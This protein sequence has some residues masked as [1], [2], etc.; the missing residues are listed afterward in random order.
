MKNMTAALLF[1]KH[2]L[3]RKA[4]VAATVALTSLGLTASAGA[5]EPVHLVIKS[6]NLDFSSMRNTN[7][8]T[9]CSIAIDSNLVVANEG[10][11]D[12]RGGYNDALIAQSCSSTVPLSCGGIIWGASVPIYQLAKGASVTY[13]P[14]TTAQKAPFTVNCSPPSPNYTVLGGSIVAKWASCRA[15]ITC[16]P[17]LA[18]ATED[19]LT[20]CPA[21][22]QKN[23]LSACH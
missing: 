2:S 1:E 19:L 22:K 11:A 13:T 8:T 6:F 5:A 21:A 14:T 10:T 18:V 16:D 17:G 20:V 23:L 4:L 9:P 12:Y 7:P 3:R 15:G